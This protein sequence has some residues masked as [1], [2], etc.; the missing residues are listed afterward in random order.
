MSRSLSAG[1]AADKGNGL[2]TGARGKD[3]ALKRCVPAL[4]LPK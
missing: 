4:A 1:H 3:D 2:I